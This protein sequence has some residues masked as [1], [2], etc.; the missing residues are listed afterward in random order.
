MSAQESVPLPQS[1]IMRSPSGS[2]SYVGPQATELCV[3]FTLRSA[4]SLYVKSGGKIIPTRGMTI[5]KMLSRAAQLTGKPYKRSQGQ[6]AISD[7]S[8]KAAALV[9]SLPIISQQ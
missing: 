9:E 5:T 8:A 1:Y 2:V 4:I 3:I 7:L 6:Q